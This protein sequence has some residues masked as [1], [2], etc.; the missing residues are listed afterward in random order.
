MEHPVSLHRHELCMIRLSR[1]VPMNPIVI[2]VVLTTDDPSKIVPAVGNGMQLWKTVSFSSF[3]TISSILLVA[4]YLCNYTCNFQSFSDVKIWWS[5]LVK[6][7][8]DH[9]KEFMLP[10]ISGFRLVQNSN[11]IQILL[12]MQV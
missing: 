10:L 3:Q 2:L 4:L 7:S 6:P 9:K 1:P 5:N 8:R 11:F 12:L